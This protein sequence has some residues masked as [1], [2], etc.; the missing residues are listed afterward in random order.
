VRA[1]ECLNV[2]VPTVYRDG[3]YA[4]VFFSSDRAEPVHIHVT[5]DGR[6]AKFWLKPVSLARNEGF[7][8]YELERI[9]RLVVQYE[10]SL[11]ERWHDYFDA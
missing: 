11:I 8:P 6:I 3:P 7:R 4:F 2:V 5:R 1:D 10:K 9:R